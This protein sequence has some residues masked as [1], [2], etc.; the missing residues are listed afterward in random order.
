MNDLEYTDEIGYTMDDRAFKEMQSDIFHKAINTL[1]EKEKK[2]IRHQ[3]E[4]RI[5]S[6]RAD[7]YEKMSREQLAEELK[8]TPKQVLRM[9]LKAIKKIM[10]F[11]KDPKI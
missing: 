1:N 5:R 10:D 8:I 11:I 7:T 9:R 6:D 4:V 2:I 3:H